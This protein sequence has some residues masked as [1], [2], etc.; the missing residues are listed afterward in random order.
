MTVLMTSCKDELLYDPSLIGEGE[1]SVSFD[2]RFESIVPALAETRTQGE[3]IKNIQNISV[4][5]YDKSFN[6]YKI[7]RSTDQELKGL[8]ISNSNNYLA[9]DRPKPGT[10]TQ[11]SNTDVATF[12]IDNI[13]F[14]IYY[15]YV[16]ANLDIKD[17]EA[18]TPDDLKNIAV[19]WEP[20]W[21]P[22]PPTTT[23]TPET[24]GT[25]DTRSANNLSNKAMFG[26]FRAGDSEATT[27]FN[28][29]PV[30]V[31]KS[32]TNL[33]AWVRRLASK[34][35]VAFDPSG[36][37]ESVFIYIKSVTIHDIP[38]TCYLGKDNT[39]TSK[40][41][42][43]PNGETIN[44]YKEG[45][46]NDPTKWLELNKGKD[47]LTD[48]LGS[49]E[50]K[51][52]DDALFFFENMQGDYEGQRAYY[53]GQIKGET[54]TSINSAEDKTPL[55]EDNNGNLVNDFKDRVPYGT[56]IEVEAYYDSRNTD[57]P[58]H[59]SS[60]PI[61]YR[62]MLGQNTTY[63]YDAIRN[64]HY[65]LT[66]KFN[67]WANEPDW[68]IVYDEP[69]PTIVLPQEYYI[70]YLYNQSMNLPVRI[71]LRE[72]D[73]DKYYLHS[74]IIE[75][76]WI[77]Y[78]PEKGEA[79]V[80]QIKPLTDINGFAWDKT[81]YESTYTYVDAE[82][83]RKPVNYVGFL[84]VRKS[85]RT[86]VGNSMSYSK[87]ALKALEDYYSGQPAKFIDGSTSEGGGEEETILQVNTRAEACYYL[88]KE[89]KDIPISPKPG[90]IIEDDGTYSVSYVKEDSQSEDNSSEGIKS[91]TIVNVPFYTRAK[92]LVSAT[93]FTGNN[94]FYA[95]Q[96]KAVVR[97]T[98]RD[99][100]TDV[101]IEFK[102][103]NL[104]NQEEKVTYK[105]IPIYQV[106]RIVNPKGI[107]RAWDNDEPFKVELMHLTD[108]GSSEF[109]PFDSEGKWRVSVIADPDNLILIEGKK[110]GEGEYYEGSTGDHIVF[111][112]QPNGK[113]ANRNQTRCGI[114]LVEYHD[115]TCN[116][117]IFV[118]QGY[119][120]PV[121]LGDADWSCYNAVA[122]SGNGSTE[123]RQ[124]PNT[125]TVK[126]M[127]TKSPLSIGS[128][129]K[130]CQ[131]NY[132]ILESNNQ[133]FGWLEN[134]N[135]QLV[136]A[137]LNGSNNSYIENLASWREFGGFAW[138]AYNYSGNNSGDRR[139]RSWADKWEAVGMESGVR[140]DLTVPTLENYQA[141]RDK[142]EYGYGIVYAD[143]ATGVIRNLD[144]ACGFTD[145][146]NNNNNGAGS[147]K[148]IRACI[149]YNPKNG[150]QILFPL[151]AVGQGRRARRI[152][153]IKGSPF[154]GI[155]AGALTY[156]GVDGLLN[157]STYRPLTY[158]LYRSPGA[159]YWFK[160]PGKKKYAQGTEPYDIASWDINYYT[161]VFNPYSYMSLG[162][163]EDNKTDHQGT[164][165]SIS[166]GYVLGSD[167]LPIKL[168]YR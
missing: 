125:E 26:Y 117:L 112:Y 38:K 4:I 15:F 89:A 20:D 155:D 111:N 81:S 87:E 91:S 19:T 134:I 102:I 55:A 57:Y 47:P 163:L 85:D 145:Y 164:N 37:N 54:G 136:T 150:D 78:N 88:D 147:T 12:S 122:T 148:G 53:K 106:R 42:L 14:G 80:S 123:P 70:S 63:N 10:T 124:V 113:L 32:P 160:Q 101:E 166:K 140:T 28:A 99:I 72:E 86:I 98:L 33:S 168:I 128:F 67:G 103:K 79:P 44:Y 11:E 83:H 45:E 69:E 108:G 107:W 16:V 25:P 61:K 62:F 137:S 39:P 46:G 131:Y 144:E 143:G 56:Y 1:G 64:H 9:P 50:H 153:Y 110:L 94:P 132:A 29:P 142:C 66:L 97:F 27:G 35:T 139:D 165:V 138:N 52:S 157:T 95:Y 68:H 22:D 18:A 41:Q 24:P 141:L 82:G 167:A 146:N 154:K 115:Y 71:L 135:G 43:I 126:V 77:P 90:S 5:V 133:N 76:N 158:N 151:G 129:F 51:D 121:H 100:K 40:D 49:T 60:G 109:L 116:H 34:V 127:V 6:L 73:R 118:R 162:G 3:A 30:T 120:A 119:D 161:L 58:D 17:E 96:R 156:G 13:P 75:N 36:L 130:R 114:I 104:N 105:D 159:I 2:M 31:N 92:E 21:I 149:V 8:S 65:H 84:S 93:D 74:E 23:D 59:L 152:S 48:P 7:Y